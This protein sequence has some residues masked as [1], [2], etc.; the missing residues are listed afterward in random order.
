MS[1]EAML[2]NLRHLY[3]NMINGGVKDAS[4]AKRLAEGLLAPI[5]EAIERINNEKRNS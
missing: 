4:Q 5:I 2:A 1:E 3:K